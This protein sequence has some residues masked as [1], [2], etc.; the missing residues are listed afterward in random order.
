MWS[1]ND[2]QLC[3]CIVKLCIFWQFVKLC[4]INFVQEHINNL[5]QTTT[6]IDTFHTDRRTHRWRRRIFPLHDICPKRPRRV[7]NLSNRYDEHQISSTS[8]WSQYYGQL[9]IHRVE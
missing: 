2:M 5:L 8:G 1:N 6:I 9:I 7:G 4:K 3:Y